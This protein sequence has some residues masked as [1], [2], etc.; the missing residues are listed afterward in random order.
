MRISLVIL[1]SLATAFGAN[2]E[3]STY[4]PTSYLSVDGN[5]QDIPPVDFDGDANESFEDSEI[6]DENPGV[7]SIDEDE[8]RDDG[9]DETANELEMNP[10][11][12][13]TIQN[14]EVIGE[15]EFSAVESEQSEVTG[16]DAQS[17]TPPPDE[18]ARNE[19]NDLSTNEV[20]LGGSDSESEVG[21][22]LQGQGTEVPDIQGDGQY[23]YDEGPTV[24]GSDGKDG[25]PD[26]QEED[27]DETFPSSWTQNPGSD[28][29]VVTPT[30]IDSFTPYPTAYRPPTL[31]PSVPYVSTDDDPLKDTD[32]FGSKI[33]DWFSNEST[34]EEM[35]H[36]RN[37]IIALSV[38]FGFMFFFSVFVAYQMLENPDGC[39][40][41]LVIYISVID[42]ETW[43]ADFTYIHLTQ[44]VFC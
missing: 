43:H 40:A 7:D 21:D 39:C 24:E 3:E 41:R 1:A 34:I 15:D 12:G 26:I 18:D 38:V 16:D 2:L 42:P 25:L 17:A 37:V 5:D 23:P 35:E 32:G 9:D 6:K 20:D 22:N 30:P 10:A 13:E 11:E 36:D 28:E 31:R 44:L 19:S 33:E 8:G 14:E 29:F 4:V 27:E